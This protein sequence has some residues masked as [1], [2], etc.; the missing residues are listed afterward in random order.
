MRL[1]RF[2]PPCCCMFSF[3]ASLGVFSAPSS[4]QSCRVVDRRVVLF[5]S[6]TWFPPPGS[7]TAT[8]VAQC[9][10]ADDNR[11][12]YSS[13]KQT[14]ATLS[15]YIHIGPQRPR[16]QVHNNTQDYQHNSTLKPTYIFTDQ[17]VCSTA[18]CACTHMFSTVPVTSSV[19]GE[20]L[21]GS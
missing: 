14:A 4:T 17:L 16:K 2:A 18:P 15:L 6:S 8:V 5:V 10:H 20:S 19:A 21:S 13:E 12:N 7:R 9:R 1:S 11:H 3:G